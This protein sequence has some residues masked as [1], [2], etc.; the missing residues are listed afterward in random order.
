MAGKIDYA[1]CK[2]SAQVQQLDK[3][4]GY[5]VHTVNVTFPRYIF[6]NMF[7]FAQ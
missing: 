6:I 3:M 4:D 1:F 2:D 5:T 7:E